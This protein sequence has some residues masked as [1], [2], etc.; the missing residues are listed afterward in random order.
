MDIREYLKKVRSV[1]KSV[2]AANG[3]SFYSDEVLSLETTLFDLKEYVYN[4]S[5]EDRKSLFSRLQTDLH[6]KDN[7]KQN[8]K[9][10]KVK[11]DGLFYLIF[12][13][14]YPVDYLMLG[15]GEDQNK[16]QKLFEESDWMTFV[17]Q[18]QHSDEK[19][20]NLM[21][22]MLHYEGQ[23]AYEYA[24]RESGCKSVVA[25]NGL[26]ESLRGARNCRIAITGPISVSENNGL[27][28]DDNEKLKD[29]EGQKYGSSYGKE[30]DLEAYEQMAENVAEAAKFYGKL[31]EFFTKVRNSKQFRG[32]FHNYDEKDLSPCTNGIMSGFDKT[33]AYLSKAYR[34]NQRFVEEKRKSED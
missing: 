34:E 9:D 16:V 21:F 18:F 10:L 14:S 2:I 17:D 8:E 25:V 24:Y 4:L 6:K 13:S 1:K 11:T 29:S 12:F 31:Y 3:K 26:T 7:T 19:K 20:R 15:A 22:L 27:S 30:Y 28:F 5:D 32:C 23:M 33:S